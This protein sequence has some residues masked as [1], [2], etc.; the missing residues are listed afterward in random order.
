MMLAPLA[1]LAFLATLW[2]VII[3]GADLFG[4]GGR[5]MVLALRGRSPLAT[6]PAIRPFA[7]RISL[8]ARPQRTWRAQPRFRAAA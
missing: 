8:R 6:A 1:T 4:A 3:I 2:L 7:A 5:K